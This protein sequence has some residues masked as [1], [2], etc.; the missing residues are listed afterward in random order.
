M[1]RTLDDV[2]DGT[3][4]HCPHCGSLNVVTSLCDPPS[5]HHARLDCADCCRWLKWVGVAIN[6][7]EA[8]KFEMPFGMYE[9]MP[10]GAIPT[11]YLRWMVRDLRTRR[12]V[13]RAQLI[14]AS[15]EGGAK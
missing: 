8:L 7:D 11:D 2:P 14:L 9:N 3:P 6:L 12:L 13:E 10:M 1:N 4:R 5:R 15:R